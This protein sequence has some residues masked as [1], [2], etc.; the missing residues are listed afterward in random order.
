[1]ATIGDGKS[2]FR[3]VDV[4][5]YSEEKYPEEDDETKSSQDEINIGPNDVE[6]QM[7]LNQGKNVE[8]LIYALNKA[9]VSTKNPVAK[10]RAVQ[11]ILRILLT[12]KSSEIEGALRQLEVPHH[13]DLLMKYIYKGFELPSEVSS[14]QLL[15]WH[16]KVFALGGLGSI[17]RVMTDR[18]RV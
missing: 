7:L 5:Q 18:K 10:A 13:T 11:S 14:A 4:D 15:S 6:I 2:S 9:P 8:A 3:K 12:F 17:V 16:E 1:M